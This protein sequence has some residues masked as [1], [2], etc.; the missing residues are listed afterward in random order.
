MCL[1]SQEYLDELD[2][3][4]KAFKNKLDDITSNLGF[5]KNIIIDDNSAAR[6]VTEDNLKA[7]ERILKKLN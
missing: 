6:K 3:K 2:E 1:I 7:F 5:K 4:E